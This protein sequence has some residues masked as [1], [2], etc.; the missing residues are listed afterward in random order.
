MQVA[1][2]DDTLQGQVDTI[3]RDHH[4][5][6]AVKIN[7]K[8]F[9][10]N[11]APALPMTLKMGTRTRWYRQLP[12]EMGCVFNWD[13]ADGSIYV[14]RWDGEFL[15]SQLIHSLGVIFSDLG[16]NRMTNDNHLVAFFR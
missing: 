13:P 3:C 8:W 7:G 5:Y 10:E 1:E 2:G 12:I 9:D 6:P 15:N 16:W 4:F 14:R 11:L